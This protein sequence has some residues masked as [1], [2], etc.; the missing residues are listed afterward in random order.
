MKIVKL[1]P[2]FPFRF[3]IGVGK[4]DTIDDLIHSDTLFSAIINCAV[5][6]YSFD[7]V[8]VLIERFIQRRIAISSVFYGVRD[9]EKEVFFFPKP[10]GRFS[11]NE[12]L[13]IIDKKK[14]K[15]IKYISSDIWTKI[16]SS[17][18]GKKINYNLLEKTA[19]NNGF[20][21]SE[22]SI[23]LEDEKTEIIKKIFIEP[24]VQVGRSRATAENLYFQSEVELLSLSEKT[25]PFLF[26]LFKGEMDKKIKA[27][28]NLLIE[29]GI[30]GERASGKG[31]FKEWDIGEINLPEPKENDDC[32]S[33]S[34]TLPAVEEVNYLKSYQLLTRNGFIYSA[35]GGVPYRKKTVRLLKEGA[36][37]VKNIKG[38]IID[39]KPEFL[40]L[41]HPVYLYGQS[42]N[43][44]LGK[45]EN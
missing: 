35:T 44:R 28:F 19:L 14:L 3:R 5:K 26:L 24:K 8:N 30:G 41:Q 1:Y 27:I 22:G 32:L 9:K 21:F 42:F 4:M 18:D 37:F 12:S 43:I 39:V 23:E 17:W 7:E 34:L 20:L 38:Q 6:L 10:F 11:S 40:K 15:N 13:N 16:L 45:N 29:E 36:I 31:W 25:T 33:L 2:E